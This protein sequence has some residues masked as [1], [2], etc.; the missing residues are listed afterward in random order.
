MTEQVVDIVNTIALTPC[1]D[2]RHRI[3][4]A[5]GGRVASFTLVEL[6]RR[7]ARVACHLR[8]LGIRARD[9]VGVMSR[10]RIEF[11]LLDLAVLKLGAVTAG[12]EPS[13]YEPDQVVRD[14]GLALLFTEGTP[15]EG[16][17][18]D[19]AVVRSW[20]EDTGVDP[21]TLPAREGYDPA[22][23]FAIKQT[24]GSTGVPKG[25]ETTAASV[26]QSM[27]AV[28]QMFDHRDGDNLMVFLP[29]RYLQQRYWIYSALVNGHDVTVADRVTVLEVARATAPTVVMGV[30]GFYEQ[31]KARIEAAGAP[32]D[33]AGRRDAIQKQLGGRIRYLWTGS[34]P[35]GRAML[36]F[37]NDAGVPLYEGYGLNE[38][39][40]VSKNHPGAF[41]V[42]SVGKVLPHKR[43]RF[44][45]DG[46]LIV[47]AE[48]PVN[49][50]YTW[51]A[52]GASERTYLPTGEVKTFD[53]GHVD[54]DGFLYIDG[55]VDDIVTLSA[56]LNILVPVVEERLRELPEVHECAVFGDGRPFLTAV[57]SPATPDVDHERLARGVAAL[58]QSLRYEQRVYAVLLAPEQFS[59]DNGLL[60]GQYKLV[61][62]RIGERYADDLDLVYRKHDVY[63]DGTAGDAPV[64]VLAAE[65]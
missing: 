31:L 44:D 64:L 7:A 29:V 3:H 24:S 10:N 14:Y 54:D 49:I 53:I 13:R 23:V 35:A 30:P 17:V 39:C 37:F 27:S 62:A 43:I 45:Q 38:T 5:E 4:F 59:I 32:A 11:V 51:S 22:D 16:A 48:Y 12:I 34:A 60:N 42:G 6:D 20:A 50:R 56:A 52:P 28:Q 9:R 33:P 46:I 47:G 15:E 61:R 25:I 8:D 41:R 58:N 40:I 1:T 21:A 2:T 36:D 57:V 18:L 55:R 26:N 19:I 65:A 63:N